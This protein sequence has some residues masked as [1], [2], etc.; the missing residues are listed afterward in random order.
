MITLLRRSSIP[1]LYLASALLPIVTKALL[2]TIEVH[3][4][5]DL[6]ALARYRSRRTLLLRSDVEISPILDNPRP[7]LRHRHKLRVRWHDGVVVRVRC[8]AWTA[9]SDGVDKL[10]KRR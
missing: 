4:P 10:V 1:P 3:L 9:N 8:V 2:R 7:A 5:I 6:M